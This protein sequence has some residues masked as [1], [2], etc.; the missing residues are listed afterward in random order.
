MNIR[1]NVVISGHVQGVAYRQS[2]VAKAQELHVTGW[3]RNLPNGD[4]EGCFEGKELAVRA[5]IDWCHR[6][7]SRA[8]V[9]RVDVEQQSYS[10]DF[11][12]FGIRY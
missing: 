11:H 6:G 1:V 2:T 5:L 4:V 3:V 9:D 8:R 12:N 7:P 10:G